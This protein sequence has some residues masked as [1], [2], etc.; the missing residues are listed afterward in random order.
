MAESETSNAADFP[1]DP[2]S[3]PE[4]CDW[5][6]SD[7]APASLADAV[8]TDISWWRERPFTRW[9][10]FVVLRIRHEPT[11][12][13]SRLY[14]LRL[15]REECYSHFAS[16]IRGIATFLPDGFDEQ[17]LDTKYRVLCALGS[18]D[19][20]R[21][22]APVGS[23]VY[24]AVLPAFQDF[25]D[26]KWRGPPATLRDVVRYL[27]RITAS[28]GHT[29][30]PDNYFWFSRNLVYILALRH[31]SFPFVL[32]TVLAHNLVHTSVTRGAWFLGKLVGPATIDERPWQPHA[33]STIQE[34]FN[35]F[36]SQEQ[37]VSPRIN[38]FELVFHPLRYSARK[39]TSTI[40]EGLDK[41]DEPEQ[42]R[43][44]F[45][46][47]DGIVITMKIER[48]T[49][50]LSWTSSPC[51]PAMTIP[52]WTV[53]PTPM[54]R[55][56]LP[57]PWEREEQIYAPAKEEYIVALEKMRS[58]L[59]PMAEPETSHAVD[60]PLIPMSIPE[61]CDW[62][63]LDKVPA[64]LADTVVTDISWWNNRLS[65]LHH[66]FVV[67]HIQYK[68]TD[69]QS[70]AYHLRLER[71]G[72]RGSADPLALDTATFLPGAFDD[73]FF[74]EHDLFCALG[75]QDYMRSLAHAKYLQCSTIEWSDT[76]ALPEFKDFLLPAFQDFLDHKWR[77]P[78]PTL[79]DVARYVRLLT[80]LQPDYSLTLANCFW[81]SRNLVT[82]IALRHYSF[83]FVLLTVPVEQHMRVSTT[84]G[85]K[86][87]Y[88]L[89]TLLSVVLN[90][91]PLMC[92][93]HFIPDFAVLEPPPKPPAPSTL[94][95]LFL[96]LRSQELENGSLLFTRVIRGLVIPVSA[97]APWCGAAGAFI[98]GF[99]QMKL[100][101]KIRAPA[102]VLVAVGGFVIAL[103][104]ELWFIPFLESVLHR[105]AARRNTSAI[106]EQL[107]TEDDSEERRGEF[108]SPDIV[109]VFQTERHNRV[110][111]W[112]SSP[113]WPAM[114][115]P[116]WTV[117]RPQIR[118]VLPEP[119][120]RDEQ[121]YAPA[122][123]EYLAALE[124]MRQSSH[125]VGQTR[126]S[127]ELMRQ[128]RPVQYMGPR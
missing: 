34:L 104:L 6:D 93:A 75:G 2:M 80:S 74:T 33:R 29:G 18:E 116:Y 90:I 36:R 24:R 118:Q 105:Y 72:K 67:L 111:S 65:I 14:H 31:Y 52:W 43:G 63:N 21:S 73:P 51:W 45:I 83:P 70:R 87:L 44:D 16:W 38:P 64:S 20:T 11:D 25:L 97:L 107:D 96:Y 12:G 48:R 49:R 61:F 28:E 89:R 5:M 57:E 62:I 53:K 9:Q 13:Q 8:V 32:L 71:A 98:L 127:D 126:V 42:Q 26:H 119:W 100:P 128:S 10:Q 60:L 99:T 59:P 95:Y 117:K 115:I 39:N 92:L 101:A 112:T 91:P 68:G 66:Q 123:E 58:T 35:Y 56:V 124:Q 109:V 4:F 103:I 22:L 76:G 46:P 106:V 37:S 108:I 23:V 122:K 120:E 102:I 55:C 79:R 30:T 85:V 1:L 78:P 121:I 69:N 19:Y 77:G 113:W 125:I 27:R 47:P 81:F 84:P 3:I 17:L 82:L 94:E 40:V 88:V 114:T 86:F 15:E 41:D 50:I 110:L 7:K 54:E